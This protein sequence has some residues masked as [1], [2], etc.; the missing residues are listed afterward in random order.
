MR[1]TAFHFFLSR[2]LTTVYRL[3]MIRQMETPSAETILFSSIQSAQKAVRSFT[4]KVTGKVSVLVP[5]LKLFKT[6]QEDSSHG[7][8]YRSRS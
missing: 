2:L 8:V 1:Y 4:K 3:Y 6:Y 7:R 5:F